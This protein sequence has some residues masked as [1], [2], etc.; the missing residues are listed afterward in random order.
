MVVI[1]VIL[2]VILGL[3][4]LLSVGAV[5]AQSVAI[6]SQ[7]AT[8]LVVACTMGLMVFVALGAGVAIGTKGSR[9]ETEGLDRE[10]FEPRLPRVTSQQQPQVP[11]GQGQIYYLPMPMASSMPL[12]GMPQ[13]P[14]Q[15]GH[16][17]AAM[18]Q[19]DVEPYQDDWEGWY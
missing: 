7:G 16:Q 13:Y 3:I 5:A 12:Q 11:Y 15:Q 18:R 17:V 9:S 10:N 19:E 4:G 2:A 14:L 8:S 6:A 1:V